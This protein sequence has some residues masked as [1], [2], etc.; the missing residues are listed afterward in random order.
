MGGNYLLNP[1]EFLLEA[2]VGLYL[3]VLLLRFLL[4]LSRADF[5]NPLSQFLF[6]VTQPLL[7]PLHRVIPGSRRI[8]GAAL[9]ALL[10]LQLLLLGL[11]AALRGQAL[12]PLALLVLALAE[13]LALTLNVYL[14]SVIVE[15][16]LSWVN[17]G[18]GNPVTRLLHSLNAPLL[19]PARRLLPPLSGIDL[20]PL[21]VLLGLQLAKLLLLPPLLQLASALR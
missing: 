6:R 8:D 13:L 1:V 2:L 10:G 21:V 17:P 19:R 16:L 9:V 11:L 12:G 15:A 20:S 3:L 7:R 4:Q 18:P 5:Y 14:V